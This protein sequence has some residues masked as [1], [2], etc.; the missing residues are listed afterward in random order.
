MLHQANIVIHVLTGTIAMIVGIFAIAFNRK[1]VIHKKLGRYF[2]YLL[3]VVV[4]SGFVGFLFFRNDPFLLMLTIIASYVGFAGFRNIQLKEKRGTWVDTLIAISALT[5]SL[6]Y[7]WNLSKSPLHWNTSVV[8]PTLVAL[9]LVTT[10]DLVKQFFLQSYLKDAWLYEHIYKMIS[11]FSAL[12]S[13][14]TGNVFRSFHPYSQIGPSIICVL[15]IIYFI[16]R[17]A[18]AGQEFCK[19]R[20]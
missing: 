3:T 12:F 6:L 5:T 1:V 2:I 8:I 19:I 17:R 16:A 11:A 18:L 9:V 4:S 15:L 14:F 10:Y 7:V 13:A 20:N